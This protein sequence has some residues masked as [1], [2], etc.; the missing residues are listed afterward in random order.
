MVDTSTNTIAV[1]RE[2]KNKWERRC[3][4]TPNEV[5]QIVELG[6]RVLVQPSSNRCYTEDQFSDAGAIIQ[7]DISEASIIF[8]VKEV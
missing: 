4:L 3:A 1:L 7:E 5:K 8:G 6:I 2:N